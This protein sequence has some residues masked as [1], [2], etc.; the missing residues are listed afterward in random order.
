MLA[1]TGNPRQPG[2]RAI[3]AWVIAALTY[4]FAPAGYVPRRRRLRARSGPWAARGG[5]DRA[6]DDLRRGAPAR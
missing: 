1:G 6:T 5:M 3:P 2:G 4:R